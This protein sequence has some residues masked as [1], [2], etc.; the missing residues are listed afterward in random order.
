MALDE[1]FAGRD[2][3][4]KIFEALRSAVDALGPVQLAVTKSQVAFRRG[5]AF[6][7]AWMPGSYLRGAHAPLV[8]TLSLRRRDSSPRW[9]EV[10]E[11]TPGRFTHHLEL[12]SAADI[13]D[14]VLGWL[15]EA[16]DA[17][18]VAKPGG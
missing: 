4:R 13:D 9:K 5:R 11:P 15:Q 14:K 18:T 17:A 2:E 12:R 10:V 16:W 7:W 1:F 8:L 6:A 3:S